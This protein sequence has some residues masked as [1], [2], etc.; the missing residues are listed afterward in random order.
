MSG[1]FFIMLHSIAAS[2]LMV[3]TTEKS[4]TA[5]ELLISLGGGGLSQGEAGR[6]RLAFWPWA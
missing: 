1:P 4:G 5:K 2:D 3:L 6:D